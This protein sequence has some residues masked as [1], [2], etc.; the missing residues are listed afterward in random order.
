[1]SLLQL[2]WTWVRSR[3]LLTMSA[4]AIALGV[5]VLFTVQ[6]VVDGYLTQV[7]TTL[8]SFGGDAT[9]RP[10]PERLGGGGSLQ[11]Y[12][13]AL[14]GVPDLGIVEPRLT[15]YGL[16]GARGSRAVADPR[17][18]DLSGLLLVGVEPGGLEAANPDQDL[19]DQEW[20]GV[21]LPPALL[22]RLGLQSG[23]MLEVLSFRSD[24]LG[25]PAPVRGSFR[26]LGEF[27]TGRFDQDL[28]RALVLRDDLANLLGHATGWSEIALHGKPGVSAEALAAQVEAA[29]LATGLTRPGF[30]TVTTWR[31]NGGNFLKAV[32]NQRNILK[33]IY[34]FL[35]LVAAYQLV[36]TLTL[37]VA[38]RRREIGVMGALGASPARIVFFFVGIGLVVALIGSVLG[39]ALGLLLASIRRPTLSSFGPDTPLFNPEVYKFATLPVEFRPESILLLLALTLSAALV[40]SFLPAWRAARL[41]IVRALYRR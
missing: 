13:D 40:F 2:A 18:R 36:A 31:E 12:L 16:V 33:G 9:L 34:L 24:S 21:L 27:T 30:P 22:Q 38:E 7:E 4:V 28:D 8:R 25:S 15:W 39:V 10:L 20:G 19:T 11:E 1:M 3:A 29:L 17:T 23:E 6:S 35:V 37:T 5:A 41:S 14:A 32:E 26:H